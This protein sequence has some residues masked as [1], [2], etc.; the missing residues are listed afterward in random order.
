MLYHLVVRQRYLKQDPRLNMA[1]EEEYKYICEEVDP[2]MS[3][4][5]QL[6]MLHKPCQATRFLAE[7]LKGGD[8]LSKC[9]K[10]VSTHI[11]QNPF[12]EQRMILLTVL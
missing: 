10:S 1:L 11:N 8:A 9:V 3:R 5:L 4:A 7:Y 12:T 2:I 6:V